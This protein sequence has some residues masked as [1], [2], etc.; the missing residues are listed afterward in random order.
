MV[1]NVC[2]VIE[3]GWLCPV[4][5]TDGR[6]MLYLSFPCEKMDVQVLQVQF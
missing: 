4:D 3:L 5:M 2:Y 1:N 6:Q